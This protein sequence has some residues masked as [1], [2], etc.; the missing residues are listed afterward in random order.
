MV[1][2]VALVSR[3]KDLNTKKKVLNIKNVDQV[4]GKTMRLLDRF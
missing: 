1:T 3:Q 2:I 4:I